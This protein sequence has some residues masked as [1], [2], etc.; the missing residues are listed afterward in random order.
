MSE[1]TTSSR[2]RSRSSSS[3]AAKAD[4]PAAVESYDDA[5]EKGYVGGPADETDHTVA[6]EIAAAEAAKAE[7]SE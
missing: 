3:S 7:A 6:G 5:L 2:T 1:P 4:E